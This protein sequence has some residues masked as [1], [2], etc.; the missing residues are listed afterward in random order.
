MATQSNVDASQP[1]FTIFAEMTMHNDDDILLVARAS[2]QQQRRSLDLMEAALGRSFAVA[3]RALA[4]STF[5][6]TT[7][8]GKS[9]FV[10]RKMAA[11]LTSLRHRAV[12]LHPVD[13]LHGD[14]GLIDSETV[15]VAF[16]KSGE[17][18][19]LLRFIDIV[20]NIGVRVIA[21]TTRESSS[22]TQRADI[23]LNAPI[24]REFDNHDIVPTASTTAAM[25]LAD[26]LAVAA[27]S[28]AGDVTDALRTSHPDG[29]I[30]LGLLR[31]VEEV[32]HAG[33]SAPL[34]RIG[35]FCS[36][37][38]DCLT[39]SSLGIVC[40][41]DEQQHLCGILTDGDIRR[42]VAR[43]DFSVQTTVVDEVMTTS[44][45]TI[46]PQATVHEALRLMENRPRQISALPVVVDGKCI[47][48]VR[49]HDA[50][51]VAARQVS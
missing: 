18:A 1:Y 43:P 17:T 12:Y 49:V 39:S 47:G 40:I 21:L 23:T 3:A 27:A 46:H 34:L 33:L 13:A 11:T 28:L 35:A 25:I 45:T 50:V 14:S 5:I 31:T 24:E 48:V 19:E 29:S 36:E 37:A 8:L 4:H 7:G 26:A 16:S 9:G 38:I 51:S 20:Q 10:A 15:V 41:V 32:M 44:P 6:V 22:L 42:L 30:G 2:F